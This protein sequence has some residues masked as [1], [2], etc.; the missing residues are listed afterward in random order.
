MNNGRAYEIQ[1]FGQHL[2]FWVLC[3]LKK[4]R[5][6]TEHVG[7]KVVGKGRRCPST[8]EPE[9]MFCFVKKVTIQCLLHITLHPSNFMFGI[10]LHML[11]WLYRCAFPYCV[12]KVQSCKCDAAVGKSS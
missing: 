5:E 2:S 1:A 6:L 11:S 8:C 10:L 7:E 3:V 9:Y 4:L 12:R